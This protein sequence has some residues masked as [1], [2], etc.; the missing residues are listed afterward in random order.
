MFRKSLILLMMMLSAILVAGCS[1]DDPATPVP[2]ADV[3]PFARRVAARL[4]QELLPFELDVTVDRAE[5][6]YRG[7]SGVVTKL[8][9]RVSFDPENAIAFLCGP[10]VMMR[11]AAR[12]LKQRGMRDSDIWVSAERN[13]KCGLGTCGHCQLGPVF[14]CKDGPVF[15]HSRI[16]PLLTR[17]EL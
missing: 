17:R 4:E 12:E 7:R 16:A 14:V 2:P 15:R 3:E 9:S 10:E 8:L 6:D 11:F 5:A 1:S 13:M